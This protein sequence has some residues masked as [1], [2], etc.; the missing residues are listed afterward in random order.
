MVNKPWPGN[1]EE[2]P[3]DGK[4]EEDNNNRKGGCMMN[5]VECREPSLLGLDA[6]NSLACFIFSLRVK[7]L[8]GRKKHEVTTG[9]TTVKAE[10]THLEWKYPP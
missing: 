1:G 2:W 9:I 4:K 3:E 6:G 7:M 10:S 8:G 5:H